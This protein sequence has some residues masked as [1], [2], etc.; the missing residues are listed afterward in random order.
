MTATLPSPGASGLEPP[1]PLKPLRALRLRSG[2]TDLRLA[3]GAGL[4][5][6]SVV[7]GS[8]LVAAADDRV[9][10]W[11]LQSSLS[12]GSVLRADDLVLARAAL[13]DPA[14]YLPSDQ[15]VEG[16]VLQRDVGAGELLPASAVGE[17]RGGDRRLVTLPVDPLH[18]PPALARGE[19][20]DVWVTPSDGASPAG[21]GAVPELVLSGALVADPG[22]G[23]ASGLTDQ[24]GVVLD[25]AAADAERAVAA[26]RAGDVDLVRVGG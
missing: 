25:V 3:A 5:V 18:A 21:P 13:D 17:G 24:V 16:M 15:D 9:E 2:R 23:D 6:L 20:V 10:V 26:A 11:S 19:R 12:A 4:V 8:R 1:E 22:A 7:L 14:A